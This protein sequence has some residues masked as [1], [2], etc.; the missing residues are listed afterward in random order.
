M[1]FEVLLNAT[2]M[3]N[4]GNVRLPPVLAR[5]LRWIVVTP[6]MHCIHH[7][8]EDDETNSNV[9]FNLPWLGSIAG[10]P[11]AAAG[12]LDREGRRGGEMFRSSKLKSL[13]D[14]K[15]SPSNCAR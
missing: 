7:S 10:A 5:A 1:V 3:F 15:P 12:R 14:S 11:P 6:D 13:S 9:G 8:A 4:H 2:S